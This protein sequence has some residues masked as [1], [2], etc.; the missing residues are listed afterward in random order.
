MTLLAVP[1]SYEDDPYEESVPYTTADRK[2]KK[3][4]KNIFKF[5]KDRKT[6][7]CAKES[8]KSETCN[9][10]KVSIIKRLRQIIFGLERAKTRKKKRVRF[11]TG[12]G[13]FIIKFNQLFF[14]V[15]S[16]IGIVYPFESW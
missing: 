2:Q 16:L 15:I 7:E 9:K 14:L 6:S 1:E 11:E 3:I 13:K 8:T 5:G 10:E 12:F 4:L